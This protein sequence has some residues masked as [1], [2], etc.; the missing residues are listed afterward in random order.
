MSCWTY[1]GIK[2][3]VEGRLS[4]SEIENLVGH[5]RSWEYLEH[6]NEKFTEWH[7]HKE[8]EYFYLPSGSEGT[9]DIYVKNCTSFK[10]LLVLNRTVFWVGGGM[11]DVWSTSETE[12]WFKKIT[13]RNTDHKKRQSLP[14]I[15]SAK[16]YCSADGGCEKVKLNYKYKFSRDEIIDQIRF[17]A[18][19]CLWGI[20]YWIRDMFEKMRD[21]VKKDDKT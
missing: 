13:E 14:L 2:F 16:G 10:N 1:A 17:L 18:I 5:I 21:S 7:D 6:V 3:V 4:V 12:E 11:R 9:L 20:K 8:D 15:L 19:E